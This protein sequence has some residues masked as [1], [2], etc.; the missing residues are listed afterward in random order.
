MIKTIFFQILEESTSKVQNC[1]LSGVFIDLQDLI[2][3]D[4][5]PKGSFLFYFTIGFCLFL[6]GMYGLMFLRTNLISLL[7][8]VELMLLGLSL[9]FAT[10]YVQYPYDLDLAIWYGTGVEPLGLLIAFMF[11]ALAAAESAIGLALIVLVFQQ[12]RNLNVSNLCLLR[13]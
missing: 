13:G 10:V 6:I 5:A 7:L 1:P 4:E 3:L 8:S 9:C 12:F 11:L 2:I